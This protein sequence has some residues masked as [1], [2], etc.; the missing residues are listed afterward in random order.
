MSVDDRRLDEARLDEMAEGVVDELRPVLVGLGVDP[1]LR[2]PGAQLALVA[3]P[4]LVRLER[5]DEAEAL[6][7]ALQVDLVAAER[8]RRVVPSTSSATRSSIVSIRSIVSWK[9]AY[10]SYHSSIVNSGWCLYETLSLRKSLP[11]S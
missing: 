1:P 7:R 2:E 9:S 6:P 8:R 11:I 10:A 3:R 4:E 5:L